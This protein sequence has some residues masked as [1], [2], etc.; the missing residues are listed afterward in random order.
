M[1]TGLITEALLQLF[2]IAMLCN[3]L[4]KIESKVLWPLHFEAVIDSWDTH[5]DEKINSG[6][7]LSFIRDEQVH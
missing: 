3:G 6:T 2:S 4:N 1:V 5:S 7:I